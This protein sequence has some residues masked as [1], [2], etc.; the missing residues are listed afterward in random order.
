M[1]IPNSIIQDIARIQQPQSSQQ[2]CT[3]YYS[4]KGIYVNSHFLNRFIIL[5]LKIKPNIWQIILGRKGTTFFRTD[6]IFDVF[7][8]KK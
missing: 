6:Q 4:D 7:L 1:W 5:T 2:C 8:R 3:Q